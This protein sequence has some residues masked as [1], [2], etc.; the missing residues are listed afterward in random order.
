MSNKGELLI[1]Y[2][3]N[4]TVVYNFLPPGHYTY[5]IY[6]WAGKALFWEDMPVCPHKT[7]PNKR[8]QGHAVAQCVTSDSKRHSGSL[9]RISG[10]CA[11]SWYHVI[12]VTNHSDHMSSSKKLLLFRMPLLTTVIYM[13]GHSD[14]MVQGQSQRPISIIWVSTFTV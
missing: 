7:I 8:P 12:V 2:T 9:I 3:N 4:A 13:V 10:G 1:L 11:L 6:D 5:T 14:D